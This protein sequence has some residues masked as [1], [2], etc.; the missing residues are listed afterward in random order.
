MMF[1]YFKGLPYSKCND[2][3]EKYETY[4]NKLPRESVIAHIRSIDPWLAC[5]STKDIFTGE[6]LTAG[7]YVDGD[8]RFPTDFLH[9][10]E[11]YDIGIPPEYEAYLVSIGVK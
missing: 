2:N 11:N 5:I 6:K 3:F 1:G 4:K 7:M 9:Y 8:F 10:Y